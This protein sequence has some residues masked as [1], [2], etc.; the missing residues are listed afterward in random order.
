MAS[1]SLALYI[2]IVI[3]NDRWE[4]VLG[5]YGQSLDGNL[6]RAQGSRMYLFEPTDRVYRSSLSYVFFV[7]CV[8]SLSNTKP[9]PALNQTK[10]HRRILHPSSS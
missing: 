7:A 10:L 4:A 1:F 9:P 3:G 8:V 5:R 2:Y 6:T